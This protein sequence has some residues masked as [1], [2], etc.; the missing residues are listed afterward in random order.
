MTLAAKN[1]NLLDIKNQ[2]P[3]ELGK[4]F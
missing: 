3:D 2:N 1:Q 4:L